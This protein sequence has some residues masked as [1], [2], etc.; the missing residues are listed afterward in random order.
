MRQRRSEA[1]QA[2]FEL[3]ITL[4]ILVLLVFGIIELGYALLQ[5]LVI[6]GI[7]REG[8]NLI[9]RQVSIG[10]AETALTAMSG[11]IRFDQDSA[12]I[13]S[14]VKLGMSG[15]NKDQAII[16]Q[17]HRFGSFA[18]TSVLVRSAGGSANSR[19]NSG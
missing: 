6:T 1:G 19:R 9:S 7:A 2:L 3:G 17:R 16:V 4:P 5:N 15:A 10:D 13:L 12:G 18:T 14:V 11:A 8:S